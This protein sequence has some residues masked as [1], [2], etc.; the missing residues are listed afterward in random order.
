MQGLTRHPVLVALARQGAQA[1]EGRL[2]APKKIYASQRGAEEA[3]RH[4][5]ALGRDDDPV[6]VLEPYGPCRVCGGW[7]LG[8]TLRQP[9]VLDANPQAGTTGRVSLGDTDQPAAPQRPNRRTR[10]STARMLPNV[11]RR[12]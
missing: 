9:V 11:P 5:R 7:H 6:K 2:C 3:L 12:R 4:L 8:R 1:A 10:R